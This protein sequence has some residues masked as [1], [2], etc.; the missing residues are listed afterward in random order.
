MAKQGILHA[1]K[2]V[3]H[4]CVWLLLHIQRLVRTIDTTVGRLKGF[5]GI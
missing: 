3:K 5:F 1:P 4:A 2:A